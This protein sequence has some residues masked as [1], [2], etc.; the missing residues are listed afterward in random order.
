MIEIQNEVP[1]TQ[2]NIPTPKK[3][4]KRKKNKS[5]WFRAR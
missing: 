5:K 4:A 2:E 1:P 3:T